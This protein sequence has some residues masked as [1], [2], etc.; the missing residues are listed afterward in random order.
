[1]FISILLLFVGIQF[2]QTSVKKIIT[3]HSVKISLLVLIVLAISILMKLWQNLFY[4]RIG[5]HINSQTLI[6]TAKDSFMDVLTTAAILVS[7]LIYQIWQLN[8]DGWVGLAVAIYI[9]IS[10]FLM[11]REFTN[12]LLGNRPSFKAVDRMT[13]ALEQY[14]ALLGFHDLLIHS[15][16][17]NAIFAT[18]DVEIDSRWTLDQAHEM[19]NDIEQ[20]FKKQLA[21]TLVCHL[22]PIDLDNRHYNE[23]HSAIKRIIKAYD[24]NLH[25]HDFHVEQEESGEVVQF[26]IVV[27]QKIDVSDHDLNQQITRDLKEEFPDI[28]TDINFDHNYIGE[29]KSTFDDDSAA[30]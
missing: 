2:L 26:D 17:P 3:P 21:V 6:A 7:A 24:M 20:D 4:E 5:H 12:Q 25:T 8:I 27:P 23:I 13:K 11:L 30:S 15:Y 18:V 1:M 22:D 9:S 10:G 28:A 29:D 14:H 19:I 16:G